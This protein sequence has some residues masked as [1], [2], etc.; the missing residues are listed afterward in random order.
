MELR[1]LVEKVSDHAACF[2]KVGLPIR[3]RVVMR[4]T[5]DHMQ[6]LILMPDRLKEAR[7]MAGRAGII[8]GIPDDKHR[9]ADP[10]A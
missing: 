1:Q 6:A 5:L 9:H 10:A 8:C 3:S 4:R 7:G 2:C